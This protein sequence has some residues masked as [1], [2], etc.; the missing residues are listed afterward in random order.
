MQKEFLQY[1]VYR[2]L[3]RWT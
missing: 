2:V 3:L 1:T